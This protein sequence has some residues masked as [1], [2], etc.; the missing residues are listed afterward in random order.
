MHIQPR[1]TYIAQYSE[2]FKYH[3]MGLWT[4]SYM[5]IHVKMY[6]WD[7]KVCLM[8]ITVEAVFFSLPT[9]FSKVNT[10]S[11]SSATS[12]IWFC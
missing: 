8:G 1:L 9:A 3:I 4:T 5:Y 12:G 6:I 10:I 2:F 7:Q 11:Y